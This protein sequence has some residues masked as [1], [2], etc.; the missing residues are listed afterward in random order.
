MAT[1]YE[2]LMDLPLFKGA[3][4]EHIS[5]LIGATKLHFLKYPAGETMIRA[6]EECTHLTFLLSGKV[7]ATMENADGRFAV[8]QT[9]VGPT[10]IS[11]DFL[12]GRY[13]QYP[14]EIVSLED[15]SALKIAKNDYIKLL[16]ADNVFL[17]N[18]LNIISANDQ[19][20]IHGILSLTSGEIDERI[21]F[22][23]S[24]LTQPGSEDIVL[25]CRKRELNAIFGV[26]RSVFETGLLS[27]K[28]R[29]LIDY[30]TRDLT[31]LDRKRL[32]DLL[33]KNHEVD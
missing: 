31:V 9:L 13:T 23:V 16:N 27:M 28:E 24:S 25:K 19:K 32:L 20:N 14:S 33:H 21:A 29:G 6:G 8:S 7:R 17:L 1:M 3:S 15:V 5:K 26:S 11:P 10:A 4:R 22:W 18:F 30:T 12:F 2:L